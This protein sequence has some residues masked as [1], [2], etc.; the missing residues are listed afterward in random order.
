MR[1]AGGDDRLV[2]SIEFVH[3]AKSNEPIYHLRSTTLLDWLFG[4]IRYVGHTSIS[5]VA[6]L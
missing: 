5:N 1:P 3:S 2:R 4:N 6:L